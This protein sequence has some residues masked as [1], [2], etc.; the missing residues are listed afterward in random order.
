ML[1]LDSCSPRA[2]TMFVNIGT[3]PGDGEGD[4]D[5]LIEADGLR[6]GDSDVDGL[7]EADGLIDGDG[8]GASVPVPVS[9]VALVPLVA[10]LVTD[11]VL[12]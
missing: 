1:T 12:L 9:V 4:A 10:L 3:S 2:G 7:S 5:G 11:R 8:D 6:V